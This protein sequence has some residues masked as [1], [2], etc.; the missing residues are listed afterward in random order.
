MFIH[1]MGYGKLIPDEMGSGDSTY[2]QMIFIQNKVMMV[3]ER[4][5]L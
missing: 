3:N 4:D 2:M 1:V 5:V